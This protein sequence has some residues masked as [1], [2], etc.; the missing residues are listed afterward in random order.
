MFGALV[1]LTPWFA[2]DEPDGALRHQIGQMLMVGFRGSSM[3]EDGPSILRGQIARGEVGGILY[4]ARNIASKED[5]QAMNRAFMEASALLPPFIA[6]DQEGGRIARLRAAVGFPTTPSA[7]WLGVN[8][9]PAAARERYALMARSLRELHFNTNLGPVVDL[10]LDARNPIISRLERS[11]SRDPLTV[12]AFAAAFV[13]AHR[14]ASLVTSLKH[15]PGHG[16]ALMDSHRGLPDV[17]ASWSPVELQPYRELFSRELADMVMVG[18]LSLGVSYGEQAVPATL[19][20]SLVTGLLRTELGFDG[21]VISDDMDMGAISRNYDLESAIIRAIRAGTDIVIVSNLQRNEPLLPLRLVTA[22][23]R[24][25]MRDRELR[26]LIGKAYGRIRAL[27]EKRLNAWGTPSNMSGQSP[28]SGSPGSPGAIV[29][30]P[31][32][33]SM[34]RRCARLEQY[35]DWT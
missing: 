14:E 31:Q 16:S 20:P 4:L 10:D 26:S 23:E 24:E 32:D 5:V 18:H 12:T 30:R 28:S 29:S 21:V 1:L 35:L 34:R 9:E 15:F 8:A 25:A 17:T 7:R 19:S 33:H 27:K 13:E 3:E 22:V 6:V 2:R 11:Y